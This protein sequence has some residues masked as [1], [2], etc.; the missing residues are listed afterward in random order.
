MQCGQEWLPGKYHSP[1]YE[2]HKFRFFGPQYSWQWF[3]KHFHDDHISN[4][5]WSI[6]VDG[7]IVGI[8]IAAFIQSFEKVL[9]GA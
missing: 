1:I 8:S 3:D 5:V 7:G 2:F 6:L 4:M 9:G